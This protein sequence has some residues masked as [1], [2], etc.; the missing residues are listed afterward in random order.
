LPGFETPSGTYRASFHME[1]A[2]NSDESLRKLNGG[3]YPIRV[4]VTDVL[5]GTINGYGL[6]KAGSG[7]FSPGS[8][9]RPFGRRKAGSW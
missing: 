9:R 6:A 3:S 5:P 7:S 4:L 1:E 2:S 8:Y